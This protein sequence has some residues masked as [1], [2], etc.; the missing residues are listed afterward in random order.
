MQDI[1]NTEYFNNT[2][3]DYLLFLGAILLSILVITVIKKIILHRLGIWAEKTE[4]NIDDSAH[5]GYQE[6]SRSVVIRR[7]SVSEHTDISSS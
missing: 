1:L 6:I 2:V 3:L 4:T 7:R 5:S